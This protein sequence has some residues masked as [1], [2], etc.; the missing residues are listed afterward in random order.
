MNNKNLKVINLWAGPGSGKSTTAAGLFNLMKLNKVS[1]ELVTEYAKQLVWEKQHSSIFQNQILLLAKQ[2]Q[3]QRV[4]VDQV[5]FCITDS[6]IFMA[7]AYQP[8]EYYSY[9]KPLLKEVFDSYNNTNFF[10]RR[11]KDY[12]SNGRNQTFEEALEKDKEIKEILDKNKIL[13]YT[14][15]ADENA[16]FKIFDEIFKG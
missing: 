7:A 8:K 16:H 9:F 15:D 1:C 4:L 6:P 2:D 11:I 3:K 5:E 12:D 10:L 14:I 13:Y